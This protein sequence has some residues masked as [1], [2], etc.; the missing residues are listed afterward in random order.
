MLDQSCISFGVERLSLKGLITSDLCTE[1]EH[2]IVMFWDSVFD[3]SSSLKYF[4]VFS[5]T[6]HT[7]RVF[8]IQ[9]LLPTERKAVQIR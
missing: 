8:L 2:G 1:H 6:H 9:Q 4:P 3:N 5:G 7:R